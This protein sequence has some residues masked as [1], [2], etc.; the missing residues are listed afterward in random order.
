M[1]LL[2]LLEACAGVTILLLSLLIGLLGL[3]MV[4]LEVNEGL[5]ALHLDLLEVNEGLRFPREVLP[6]VKVEDAG[7]L[8]ALRSVKFE[9]GVSGFEGMQGNMLL[10]IEID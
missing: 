8:E 2:S 3:L 10:I 1:A 9:C 7:M 5:L 4:L 6:T